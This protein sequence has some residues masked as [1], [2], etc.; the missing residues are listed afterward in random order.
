[1]RQ[2]IVITMCALFLSACGGGGSSLAIKSGDK[3]MSFSAKSSSTDFG[4]VIATSPG[5]PDL[6]TSVHT[7]YL[8]NYEMDTTNVGTMRKPLTSADQIR[9]EFSVTGEAATNE[10]TPFKIG[11]YAVTNDKINDIRY[12]KVTTFADGKEN[13][14]DFDTMSSMSKIT[15]EVKITSVTETE[16]SGSI[17]I[18]E[19]DKSVKGNFTAKIAK[20]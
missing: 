6:Q 17:D 20:K 18:T 7:I 11:T 4:N 13:K 9:V 5:K 1:M 3:S 8:A 14:I 15:G 12:V 2:F 16:L 10:K 19:G